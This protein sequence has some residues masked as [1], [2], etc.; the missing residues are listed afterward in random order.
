MMAGDPGLAPR[1]GTTWRSSSR[2]SRASTGS[3]SRRSPRTPWANRVTTSRD[4]ASQRQSRTRR[5]FAGQL[6]DSPS[7]RHRRRHRRTH[8]ILGANRHLG[9][10]LEAPTADFRAEADAGAVGSTAV[11]AGAVMV[12]GGVNH[13][14]AKAADETAVAGLGPG[15]G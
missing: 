12:A 5:T 3:P 7:Q 9:A 1:L 6:E 10:L 11:R 15:P 13:A 4:G 2:G 8:R 14:G